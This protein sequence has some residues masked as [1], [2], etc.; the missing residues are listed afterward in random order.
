MLTAQSKR[1]HEETSSFDLHIPIEGIRLSH[2]KKFTQ[3][4]RVQLMIELLG[5]SE[6]A[7]VKELL[8]LI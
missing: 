4:N 2:D 8:V 1:W 5:V 6:V 3:D 7:V